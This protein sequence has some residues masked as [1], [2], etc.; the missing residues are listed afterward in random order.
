VLTLPFATVELTRDLGP[1]RARR[2]VRAPSVKDPSCSTGEG[3]ISDAGLQN[4]VV[5]EARDGSQKRAIVAAVHPRANAQHHLRMLDR[6]A[7]SP[8]VSHRHFQAG[9]NDLR[10]HFPSAMRPLAAHATNLLHCDT[11]PAS[12]CTD[13]RERIS[14]LC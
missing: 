14:R 7:A 11:H 4:A 1:N 12:A 2:R 3:G 8:E 5:P 6:L 9:A 10:L 13:Q